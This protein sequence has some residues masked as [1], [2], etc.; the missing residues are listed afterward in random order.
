MAPWHGSRHQSWASNSNIVGV[1]CAA[2]AIIYLVWAAVDPAHVPEEL[3]GLLGLA[4]GAWFS[5]VSDDKR[6]KD[7]DVKNT[8]NRAEAK[9][10]RLTDVAEMEHPGSTSDVAGVDVNPGKHQSEPGP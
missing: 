10:D 5:A 9:V 3:K 4:G 7:E 8:A 2:I 6:R 1:S